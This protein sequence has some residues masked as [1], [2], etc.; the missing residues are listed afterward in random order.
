LSYAFG[1]RV[2]MY[3]EYPDD[4]PNEL[5]VNKLLSFQSLTVL[6]LGTD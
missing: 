2:Y 3:A 4:N 1:P 5:I 6:A